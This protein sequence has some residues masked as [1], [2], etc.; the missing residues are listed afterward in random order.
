VYVR[1]RRSTLAEE[2]QD[3]CL[4]LRWLS[5]LRQLCAHCRTFRKVQ[6]SEC[7]VPLCIQEL[8]CHAV[9]G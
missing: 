5:F 1:N 7:I 4:L 9:A 2:Q 6:E 3:R 8:G